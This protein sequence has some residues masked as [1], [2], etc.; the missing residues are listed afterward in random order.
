M[1]CTHRST[2]DKHSSERVVIRD[3]IESQNSLGTT[4]T[5]LSS[6]NKLNLCIPCT[7]ER[8][9]HLEGTHILVADQI[10]NFVDV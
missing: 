5:E 3:L 4:S 10:T 8:V 7:N 6:E 2:D 9:L 1:K